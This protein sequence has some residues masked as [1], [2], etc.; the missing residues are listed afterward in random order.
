M[1]PQTGVTESALGW[2]TKRRR[3]SAAMPGAEKIPNQDSRAL[4]ISKLVGARS[5]LY[6]SRLFASDYWFCII[7]RDLHWFAHVWTAP[8]PKFAEACRRLYQFAVGWWMLR[9]LQKLLQISLKYNIF[10]LHVHIISVGITVK[11]RNV[12]EV[13]LNC[14]QIKYKIKLARLQ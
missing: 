3:S 6:R 2:R 8:N 9:I 1:P 4:I 14:S 7:L 11:S 12:G 10:R 13:I 5:Q